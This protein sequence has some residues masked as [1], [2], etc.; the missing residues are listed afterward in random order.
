[1]RLMTP[2]QLLAAK[3]TLIKTA[4]GDAACLCALIAVFDHIKALE[5]VVFKGVAFETDVFEEVG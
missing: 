1:M 2:A 5:G 4:N 3:L